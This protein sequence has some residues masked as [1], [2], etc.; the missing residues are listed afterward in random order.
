L[1]RRSEPDL[2]WYVRPENEPLR[3]IE[4]HKV[5]VYSE[6][7]NKPSSRSLQ[8]DSC[9]A[10]VND[11]DGFPAASFCSVCEGAQEIPCE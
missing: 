9:E 11:C 4:I 7:P 5:I 2:I 6:D 3:R 10:F 8:M 1:W